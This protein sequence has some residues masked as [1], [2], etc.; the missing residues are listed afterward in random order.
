[1]IFFL[2]SSLV[3]PLTLT[4]TSYESTIFMLQVFRNMR[5]FAILLY[6]L[7]GLNLLQKLINHSERS[8]TPKR[9]IVERPEI[10]SWRFTISTKTALRHI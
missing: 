9:W 4:K 5:L 2:Y 6:S 3:A 10:E 7:A 1:M 8:V